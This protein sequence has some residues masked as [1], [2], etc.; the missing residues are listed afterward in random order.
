MSIH[1][2]GSVKEYVALL[3][4]SGT[5]AP[6]VI[7]LKNTLDGTPVWT[8][9]SMGNYDCT[10]SGA[11]PLDTTVLEVQQSVIS[12][13]ATQIVNQEALNDALVT[14][15]TYASD[16]STLADSLLYKTAVKIQVYNQY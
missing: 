13:G 7:V 16:G 8:R 10:L 14:V 5:S 4:Q 1:N 15:S 11:F 12:L 6:V 2:E 9:Q 3:T